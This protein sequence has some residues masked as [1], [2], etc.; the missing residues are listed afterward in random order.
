MAPGMRPLVLSG[1]ILLTFKISIRLSVLSEY[2]DTIIR[3]LA[4]LFEAVLIG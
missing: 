4:G 2:R 3:E 1:L